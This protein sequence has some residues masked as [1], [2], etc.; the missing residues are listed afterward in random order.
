MKISKVNYDIYARAPVNK[1][2]YIHTHQE[3]EYFELPMCEGN[4]ILENPVKTRLITKQ[5]TKQLESQGQENIIGKKIGNFVVIG[6]TKNTKKGKRALYMVRC[7]CGT[8]EL[9][10]RK[11]LLNTNTVTHCEKCEALIR[12]KSRYN[13]F[14]FGEYKDEPAT[15]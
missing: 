5:Y 10:K 3:D 13:K 1:M 2:A 8:Y 4:I 6:L 12:V 14:Q 15:I 9:R 11:S 7:V